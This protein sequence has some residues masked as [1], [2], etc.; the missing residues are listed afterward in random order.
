MKCSGCRS[1][2]VPAAW[3]LA[4]RNP[5]CPDCRAYA[6]RSKRAEAYADE[7]FAGAP[8]GSVAG[9]DYLLAYRE[10]LAKGS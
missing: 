5:Y 10:G 4:Q 1:R 2:F 7:C 3:Q 9:A 6:A 8:R